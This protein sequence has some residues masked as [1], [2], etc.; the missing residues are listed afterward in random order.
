MKECENGMLRPTSKLTTGCEGVTLAFTLTSLHSVSPTALY[1]HFG[2]VAEHP[3]TQW[4]VGMKRSTV[5]KPERWL[6]TV[7]SRHSV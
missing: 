3:C 1:I 4:Y 6:K 2:G 7:K 5:H